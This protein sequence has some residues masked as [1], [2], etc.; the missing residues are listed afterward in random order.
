MAALIAYCSIVLGSLMT[1]FGKASKAEANIRIALY[2]K[3]R[4]GAELVRTW[5]VL[6]TIGGSMLP[7]RKLA[8]S[9]LT[10]K[11]TLLNAE[12]TKCLQDL[13]L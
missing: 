4:A 5:R 3:D 11:E 8:V 6:F 13:V 9:G 10:N 7:H 12:K 2:K 1:D